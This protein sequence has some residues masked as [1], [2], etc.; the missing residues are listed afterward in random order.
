MRVTQEKKRLPGPEDPSLNPD[1]GARWAEVGAALAAIQ[2]M[3]WGER[4][5]LEVLT[6][7]LRDFVAQ[8]RS[9]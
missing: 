7:E 2:P 8:L 6:R 5:P 4:I 3:F 9:G 1:N